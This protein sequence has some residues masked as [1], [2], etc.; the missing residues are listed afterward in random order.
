MDNFQM[1]H[2]WGV[3][4]GIGCGLGARYFEV[5]IGAAGAAGVAVVVGLCLL[6]LLDAF[7]Q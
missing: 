1:D 3:A 6:V 4:A 7:S 5:V 2:W